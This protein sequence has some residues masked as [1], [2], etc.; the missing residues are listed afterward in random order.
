MVIII[1][2]APIKTEISS[3]SPRDK[4]ESLKSLVAKYKTL[5]WPVTCQNNQCKDVE[6]T[7]E[8]PY[9]RPS[10]KLQCTNLPSSQREEAIWETPVAEPAQRL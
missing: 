2:K 1:L 7:L 6:M 5:G 8:L 3:A 10:S 4:P 9:P